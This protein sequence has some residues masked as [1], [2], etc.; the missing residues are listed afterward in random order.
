[1]PKSIRFGDVLV[2]VIDGAALPGQQSWH[3]HTAGS[4]KKSQAGTTLRDTDSQRR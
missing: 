1:M 4:A 3:V 2:V